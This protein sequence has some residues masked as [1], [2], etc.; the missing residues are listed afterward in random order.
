MAITMAAIGA[1]GVA[2]I[3]AAAAATVA[4]P[5]AAPA[6]VAPEDT[7]RGSRLGCV[8]RTSARSARQL[9]VRGEFEETISTLP[10]VRDT[11]H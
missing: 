6:A 4:P 2:S 1:Y 3:G 7:G 10:G 9:T 5:I 11:T 8:T